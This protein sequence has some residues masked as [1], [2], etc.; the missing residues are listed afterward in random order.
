[1][2]SPIAALAELERDQTV[3]P[4]THLPDWSAV[5]P[6]LIEPGV[7]VLLAEIESA[8]LALE[9][10]AQPG[11]SSLMEP[12]ERLNI[13]LGR[14][15]GTISHLL[16]V[17]YSD[18]LQAAYDVIRPK[19]VDLGNRMS[20][21]RAIYAALKTMQSGPGWQTLG[22]VRQRIAIETLRGMERAGVHLEEA[23]RQRF[24]AIQTRLSELANTF[25]TNLVKAERKARVRLTTSREIAGI[26]PAL[27]DMAV[28]TAREDGVAHA[29]STDGPW[30]FIVNGV[31]YSLV[32]Y[33]EDPAV[34]EQF[35]R[36]YKARGTDADLDN[37]PV[38]EEILSLRQ[39]MAAL[40]GFPN[41]V[42]YSLDAKMADSPAAVWGLMDRLETAAKPAARRE[43]TELAA[44]AREQG[45]SGE[46]APWDVP[47]WA[48]KLELA[49]F[50]YDNEAIRSYFQLPIV[51]SGL[52]E[53][54]G[55]LYG[56][57]FTAVT[58]GSVP[59]WHQDVQFY[60]VEVDSR[61]IAGFFL[62]PYARPGEKRGG[63]WMN[64]VVD[65]NR[66]LA[67][68][69]NTASLPV[70]LLVMNAR[71]PADGQPALMS[72]DEV[73]TLFHEFGHATQLL[74]TEVE[75]GSASGLNLVEWDAVELA[76]QF[77]E[78]WMDHK[79][80]LRS[81]SRHIGTGETLSDSIA[82]RIIDGA[83]FMAGN[84]TLRQ[85]MFAKTDLRIHE[86]FGLPGANESQSP[87]AI[88][89]SVARDTLVL[90]ALPD[91]SQLP[92]FSHLFAGGYAAGYYSYKW[93][94]VL[95][96]DAFGAFHDAGLEDPDALRGVA[97]RF[98]STV[99]ALGGSLPAGEIF[100]MFRGRDAN[101]QALLIKQGLLPAAAA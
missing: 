38:L 14:S 32:T 27:L 55:K 57:T 96:A 6:Q 71:P 82:A 48:E 29:T 46:L 22:A 54:T 3:G 8:F 31:N 19:F 74:F 53:L 34:R 89:Q 21:S 86:R 80:F 97:E 85:L 47:Y 20:Q 26:P 30:H 35:Y 7:G 49:R 92:A 24:Q 11:W 5:T 43:L 83:N 69:S 37:R 1:M 42:E 4:L 15:I 52:F 62:D 94:E 61:T 81:L 51:L 56:A 13:R 84:A 70:A 93:A 60:R 95:A 79:P 9:R 68:N 90:P 33:A 67:S 73:R 50:G 101:P 18:E 45:S 63:A 77:N 10:S 75:E 72:L 64:T 100:R 58:D 76:S 59:L 40:V 17:R 66:L 78:Y 41:Y 87:Q 36:A 28:A 25:S 44:F 12:L 16:S 98:K 23:P 88:E 65:R 91:E 99:L 2:I 39:E